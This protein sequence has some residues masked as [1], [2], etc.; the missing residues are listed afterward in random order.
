MQKIIHWLAKRFIL[1]EE[2]KILEDKLKILEEKW[3]VIPHHICHQCKLG[4]AKVGMI[5]YLGKYFHNEVCFNEYLRI[6]EKPKSD[7][8]T[9]NGKPV[10]YYENSS[11]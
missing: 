1:R 8:K 2:F 5:E 7:Y 6:I 10:K 4:I 9:I 3:E 11:L